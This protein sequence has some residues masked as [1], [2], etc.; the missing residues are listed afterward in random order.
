MENIVMQPNSVRGH[1]I[2]RNGE[3]AGF[4]QYNADNG[5]YL[6]VRWLETDEAEIIQ[7]DCVNEMSALAV[8]F[9]EI[10]KKGNRKWTP[11]QSVGNC[12]R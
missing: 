11:V 7:R 9:A 12:Q 5:K 10:A 4:T 1:S 2:L 3:L 8:V 6:A